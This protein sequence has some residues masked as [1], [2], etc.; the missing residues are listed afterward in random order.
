MLANDLRGRA[1]LNQSESRSDLGTVTGAWPL[2]SRQETARAF[3]CGTGASSSPPNP[4]SA[5]AIQ[6]D[7]GLEKAEKAEERVKLGVFGD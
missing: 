7:S 1:K 3:Q 6:T 2:S 4:C 5:Q